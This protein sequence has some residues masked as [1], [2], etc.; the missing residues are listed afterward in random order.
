[1]IELA[2]DALI[3]NFP[4]T[5]AAMAVRAARFNALF[6]YRWDRIVAF[7]KLHYVLSKRTEPYWA[8]H[9]RPGS[10]PQD[11]QDLLQVWTDQAPSDY[12]LG[13]VNEVFPAASY[14]YIL[15]GMGF[16]APQP[17]PVRRTRSD[18]ILQAIGQVA[19]RTRSL[20]SS[21]PSNRT[22]LKAL[23]DSHKT[24]ENKTTGMSK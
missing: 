12:D 22:Y 8:D 15:Y 18:T 6:R 21:L 9:R 16:A 1:M 3:D 19:A 5:R 14:A 24:P 23:R 10:I 7:L 13:A 2:L 20:T 11:L 17:G 4:R